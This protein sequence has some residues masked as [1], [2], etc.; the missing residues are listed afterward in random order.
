MYELRKNK[1][2]MTC[3]LGLHS[4]VPSK[5]RT[6]ATEVFVHSVCTGCHCTKDTV[7]DRVQYEGF[8]LKPVKRKP[9]VSPHPHHGRLRTA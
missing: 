9:A 6:S 5:V 8:V 3:I 4:F 1:H 2:N 7:Q